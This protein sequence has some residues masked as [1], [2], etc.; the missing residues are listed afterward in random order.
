MTRLIA[1]E[2]ESLSMKR[3]VCAYA[4]LFDTLCM[5]D[6]SASI[7]REKKTQESIV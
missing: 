1:E 5:P 7:K 2:L 4:G 6:L 3:V